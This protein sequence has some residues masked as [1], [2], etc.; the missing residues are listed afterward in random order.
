MACLVELHLE[1]SLSGGYGCKGCSYD[2]TVS[3]VAI[4]HYSL[5]LQIDQRTLGSSDKSGFYKFAANPATPTNI[6][7]HTNNFRPPHFHICLNYLQP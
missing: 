3:D 4:K 7:P 5:F 6:F 1:G 2:W